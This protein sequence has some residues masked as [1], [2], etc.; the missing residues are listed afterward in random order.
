MPWSNPRQR[1]AI[2]L[3]I[4]RKKGERAAR[5]FMHRHGYGGKAKRRR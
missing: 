3:A 5:E 4:K 1:N 2:F